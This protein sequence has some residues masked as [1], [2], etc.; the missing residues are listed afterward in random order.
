MVSKSVDLR[1]LC[2]SGWRIFKVWLGEG[3]SF[4][5]R[6]SSYWIVTTTKFWQVPVSKRNPWNNVSLQKT[7]LCS[8]LKIPI[9]IYWVIR[10]PKKMRF[11]PWT[12]VGENSALKRHSSTYTF[13]P[14]FKKS[15]VLPEGIRSFW[16]LSSWQRLRALL[17][18]FWHP[19]I[20]SHF[21]ENK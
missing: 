15:L 3:L 18:W 11:G 5:K 19:P 8:E 4:N 16:L 10:P 13:I 17:T 20:L 1:I 14:G 7:R 12:T 2:C 21:K 9:Y 6:M